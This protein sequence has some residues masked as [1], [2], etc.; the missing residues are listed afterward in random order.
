MDSTQDNGEVNTNST[1]SNQVAQ[2]NSF[3][4]QKFKEDILNSVKEII[5]D[6][7]NIQSMKDKTLAEMKKD[8][9]FRD[10]F[11]EIQ[12]MKESGMTDREIELEARLREIEE[13]R[14]TTNNPGKVV[15][16][17]QTDVVGLTVKALELDYNDPDVLTVI[18]KGNLEEQIKG[19]NEVVM[20]KQQTPN[21][22]LVAQPAGG[23]TKPDLLAEYQARASK[24]RGNALIDL[25]M[26][27][28][29]KGLD[30]N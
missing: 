13:S 10:I 27:Y 17:D 4:Q 20:R 29:K 11:K 9:G 14:V 8:K 1:S 15:E 2:P 25:K 6:P 28:R 5:S 18:S 3:D 23:G 26:E 19:L 24:V 21:P 12:S 22:A 16:R 30:I 7:R